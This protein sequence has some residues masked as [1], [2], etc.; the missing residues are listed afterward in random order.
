MLR[1]FVF[2]LSLIAL[3]LFGFDT[4]ANGANQKGLLPCLADDQ[5]AKA[6]I[7]L[8]SNYN[9]AQAAQQLLREKARKSSACREQIIAAVMTAMDKPNLDISRNQ[10]HADLW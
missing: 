3:T 4:S 7:S 5:L 8:S 2:L 6:V 10:A 9:E 1:L